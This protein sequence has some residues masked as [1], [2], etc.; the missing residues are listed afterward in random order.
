MYWQLNILSLHNEWN[1]WS[2]PTSKGHS[3]YMS[4]VWCIFI[5]QRGMYRRIHI[6]SSYCGWS[7]SSYSLFV[8][9]IGQDQ[10]VR[11]MRHFLSLQIP[12]WRQYFLDHEMILAN[13]QHNFFF[14]QHAVNRVNFTFDSYRSN[15]LIKVWRFLTM[16]HYNMKN[17]IGLC[18]SS[19]L[20]NNKAIIFWKLDF[21][22]IFK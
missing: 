9:I 17:S 21:A 6:Q 7:L 19:K 22:S 10:A 4:T 14:N 20:Q 8:K 3:F 1:S 18:Q 5:K 12:A 11:T 13:P 16:M 15:A 2:L